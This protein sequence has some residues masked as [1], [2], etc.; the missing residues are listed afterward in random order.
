MFNSSITSNSKFFSE[1]LQYPPKT[2]YEELKITQP[3]IYFG[4]QSSDFIVVNTKANEFDYPLG[5]ENV[6]TTYDGN[7]GI[8]L[9]NI[10][11]KAIFSLKLG[12]VNLF[13]S[14]AV[15][16]ESKVLLKRDIV[17]RAS[18]LAPFLQ[19]DS[20]PYIVIDDGK[21]FWEFV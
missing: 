9:S 17:E 19:Y 20:D 16:P 2:E 6:F 5:N 15:T 18:A 14:S 10:L 4:E 7:D 11:R 13:V 3:R 21:L 8:K 12:S 1:I